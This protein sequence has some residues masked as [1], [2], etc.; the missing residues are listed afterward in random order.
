[1]IV[2]N[3]H[4][5]AN[6]T[7]SKYKI[8][9]QQKRILAGS[10]TSLVLFI[11]Y[12][13]YLQWCK[14]LCTVVYYLQLPLQTVT[15]IYH[16]STD[17]NSIYRKSLYKPAMLPR[18][19]TACSATLVCSDDRRRMNGATAAALTTARVC[20][21]VPDATLVSAHAASNWMSGLTTIHRK[22]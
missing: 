3:L 1:M 5:H 16:Q 22:F 18:A 6:V 19:H 11:L 20:C 12:Q 17:T 13:I 2:T 9:S 4:M 10:V 14:T 21:D 15:N 8:W 7:D